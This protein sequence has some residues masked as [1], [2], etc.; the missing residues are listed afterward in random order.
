MRC[1]NKAKLFLLLCF[2]FPALL[3]LA[4]CGPSD[5]PQQ[6]T[7]TA[8]FAG[9]QMAPSTI[10]AKQGDTITLKIESDNPGTFHLHGYDL[11]GES[12]SG[13][14]AEIQFVAG[15]TGRFPLTFHGSPVGMET[16]MTVPSDGDGAENAGDSSAMD[17]G[18]SDHGPMESTV[19]VEVDIATE[20]DGAG[21]LHISIETEGWRWAPEE[22]NGDNSPGAGHAHVYVDGEKVG[23]IYGSYHYLP[24]LEPG[25][26]EVR[27]SLNA[28]G[29]NELTWEGRPLEAS[30]TVTAP[31]GGVLDGHHADQML[32]VVS[33]GAPMSLDI[34]AHEDPLGGYNLQVVPNGFEFAQGSGLPHAAGKGH[35]Q[36]AIDGETV[37]KLFVPWLKLPAQGEGM[38]TFTVS[39]LNN[40][41]KPYQYNG[42]RV[43]ESTQV[44]EEAKAEDAD[45]GMAGG[46]DSSDADSTGHESADEDGS[47]GLDSQ[48]GVGHHGGDAGSQ[49]G[50]G[51]HEQSGDGDEDSTELEVGYLEVLP[52]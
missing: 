19:P 44:H 36:I 22:V 50:A 6:I 48:A 18:A 46:H 28:N 26:H 45:G 31:G 30:T 41:G 11:E 13:T 12:G 4:A 7:V 1:L 21:G 25:S 40:E 27:V 34:L 52:R 39:L 43:E 14:P 47:S 10:T 33:A 9:G 20:L 16:G 38:H 51:H 17:H 15:A 23:R 29:H 49:A 2:L 24:S 3:L 5:A 42:N 35:A 37:S 32:E 8:N